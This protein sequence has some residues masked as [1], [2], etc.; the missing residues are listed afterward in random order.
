[1]FQLTIWSAAPL[2]TAFLALWAFALARRRLHVPGGKS[3][4]NLF[5]LIACWSAAHAVEMLLVSPETKLIATQL[6]YLGIV[7]TPVV[8]LQFA[9]TF[10]QRKMHVAKGTLFIL[11]II[12]ITTLLIVS[13]NAQHGLMWTDWEVAFHDG[14]SELT[15]T[16]GQWFYVHALYS[17]ALVL[18]ATT[19]VLFSLHQFRQSHD[20]V[21]AA[22]FAPL[23]GVIA[24]AFSL[25]SY[26]PTPWVD[27]TTVGFLFGILL[28]QRG[29]G[30]MRMF[31]H[32]PVV[33]DRVVEQLTDPILVINHAGTILDVNQSALTTWGRLRE[34]IMGAEVGVLV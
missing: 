33:R 27:Y 31:Q 34:N 30:N 16:P 12:P 11:C 4:R 15:T 26:N 7:F 28:L 22:L 8:W 13:T 23:L 19:I 25:S 3:L 9:L 21:L 32:L 1:M 2:L 5:L 18:V 20:A 17:Y 24:N 10:G 6:A 29:V 14:H